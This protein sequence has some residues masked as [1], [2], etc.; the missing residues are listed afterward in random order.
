MTTPTPPTYYNDFI[1]GSPAVRGPTTRQPRVLDVYLQGPVGCGYI[2]T[3]SFYRDERLGITLNVMISAQTG[4]DITKTGN[5]GIMVSYKLVSTDGQQLNASTAVFN[6]PKTTLT[7]DNTSGISLS[8]GGA[9]AI[10]IYFGSGVTADTAYTFYLVNKTGAND[11]EL[12]WRMQYITKSGASSTG[13]H[14]Y[15]VH[16]SNWPP[17]S[18]SAGNSDNLGPPLAYSY[19]STYDGSGKT[20]YSGGVSGA[21]SSKPYKLNEIKT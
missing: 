14:Q 3:P 21:A 8:V 16:Q 6:S 13:W 9:I 2:Y 15:G 17:I 4:I 12:I 7:A 11:G 19:G 10:G 18:V 1:S 5:T 20:G